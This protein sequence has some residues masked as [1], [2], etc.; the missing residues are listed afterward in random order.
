MGWVHGA[1]GCLF[2]MFF[3]TLALLSPISSPLYMTWLFQ[4]GYRVMFVMIRFT[5]VWLLWAG[6]DTEPSGKRFRS[7]CSLSVFLIFLCFRSCRKDGRGGKNDTP[8]EIGYSSR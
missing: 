2:L 8:A 4:R 3:F 6:G 5:T 7:F 1:F